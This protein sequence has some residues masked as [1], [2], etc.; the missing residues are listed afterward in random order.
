[1]LARWGSKLVVIIKILRYMICVFIPMNTIEFLLRMASA[2]HHHDVE[3][4][5]SPDVR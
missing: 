4:V 5:D 3:R 2:S 1:M